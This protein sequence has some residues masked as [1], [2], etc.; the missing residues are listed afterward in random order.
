MKAFK[1]PTQSLG[2]LSAET[3]ANVIETATDIALVV[4][5]EGVI[6]D[7][8]FQQTDLS[9]ELGGY[10]KWFGRLWTETVTVESQGKVAALLTKLPAIARPAGGN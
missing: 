10:G 5:G 8:A 9:A 4:D 7:V 2:N 6:Q 1:A 3:A